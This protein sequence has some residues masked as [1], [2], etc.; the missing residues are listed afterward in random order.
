MD[1]HQFDQVTIEDVKRAH[2][3]DVAIQDKY[4]V[5]YLQYWV[6]EGAGTVFCLTEGPDKETCELV[7]KMAHGM[8]P[9]A[10][11]QVETGFYKILMGETPRIDA[12]GL[13]QNKDGTADLG[14]RTVLT[15]FARQPIDAAPAHE[16][17]LQFPSSAK[18]IALDQ[19]K[20]SSGR[21]IKTSEE[22]VIGVFNDSTD[23]VTSALKIRD[24]LTADAQKLIVRM[25]LSA[26][27]PLTHDGNFFTRAIELAS[28]LG[29]VAAENEVV[30]SAMLDKICKEDV[31]QKS[32]NIKRI[33]PADE[34]LIFSLLKAINKPASSP[35]DS[36][37][38]LCRQIGLSRTQ[39]YRKLV[40]LTGKAPN[41]FLKDIRL[42]KALRLLHQKT[43]NISEVA[44]EVGF[45]N[46]SYFSRCF[47]EKFGCLPSRLLG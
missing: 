35:S 8:L 14:Y 24:L 4:G 7:H 43:H 18:A 11:T 45:S 2:M 22:Q 37:D 23:A 32:A 16:G 41:D 12:E 40:L 6:N 19:I 25:G 38:D 17:L 33:K 47:A 39:L 30:I 29:Q 44:L 10:L 1:F 9:C 36:I 34:Q 21:E 31:L 26:E 15:V 28:Y 5:K 13:V 27:Q 42:E 46:P 3:A 20:K